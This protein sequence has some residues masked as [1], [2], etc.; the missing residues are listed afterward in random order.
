MQGISLAYVSQYICKTDALHMYLSIYTEIHMQGIS[1]AYIL[2]YICKTDAL[3]MYLSIY[4][5]RKLLTRF[6]NSSTL[7][8]FFFPFAGC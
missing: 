3:H 6:V 8:L 4:S 5:S 1:L 2:R 7:L